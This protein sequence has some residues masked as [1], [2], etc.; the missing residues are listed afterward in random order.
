MIMTLLEQI[1]A[2]EI[3]NVHVDNAADDV[4]ENINAFLDAMGQ[5]TSIESV[6]FEKEFIGDLRNDART[7]LLKAIGQIPSIK[8]IRLGDA[9]LQ[10]V[11]ITEMVTAAQ[12]LRAL[13]L[14]NI[15]LQG[16]AE[17]FDACET[18]LYKSHTLKEFDLE[19]CFPAVRG[20]SLEKLYNAGKKYAS[21]AVIDATLMNEQ[22]AKT[23]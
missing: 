16:V 6:H 4:F 19:D 3:T 5:N 13:H 22:G 12:A 1:Q 9:L 8:E 20:L 21:G 14:K 7:K 11:D 2:N 18:A 23:A 15:V 17:H 10:T